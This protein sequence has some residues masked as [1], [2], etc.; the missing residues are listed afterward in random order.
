MGGSR[1]SRGIQCGR[2]QTSSTTTR[3]MFEERRDQLFQQCNNEGF[4]SLD[5]DLLMCEMVDPYTSWSAQVACATA[6]KVKNDRENY[7]RCH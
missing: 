4:I 1:G 2:G 3:S 6:I 7:K 5:Q